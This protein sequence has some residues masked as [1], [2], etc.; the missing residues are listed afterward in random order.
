MKTLIFLLTLIL[1]VPAFGA[2]EKFVGCL[3]TVSDNTITV[4]WNPPVDGGVVDYYEVRLRYLDARNP[5]YYPIKRVTGATQT[6]LNQPRAG[7]FSVEVR[8]VNSIGAGPWLTSTQGQLTLVDGETMAWML[9]WRLP[10]TGP[11]IIE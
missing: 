6:T 9:Y 7:H 8:A 3:Y 10:G 11:V 5:T 1:A 4:K 2:A